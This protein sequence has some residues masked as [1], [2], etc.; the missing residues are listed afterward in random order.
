MRRDTYGRWHA[1]GGVGD[2]WGM[3]LVLPLIVIDEPSR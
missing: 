3:L 1:R 2:V